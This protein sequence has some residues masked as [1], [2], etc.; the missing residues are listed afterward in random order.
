M[1]PVLD[2]IL[3][4]QSN[5]A[6]GAVDAMYTAL[7]IVAIPVFFLVLMWA[8]VAVYRIWAP[9]MP[10]PISDEALM[11]RYRAAS[12]VEAQ[13]A[14]LPVGV[15]SENMRKAYRARSVRYEYEAGR[16]GGIPVRWIEDLWGRRN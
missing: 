14:A 4:K 5:R 16:S 13:S 2:Q 7:M 6:G 10:E 11:M 1:I 12:S 9:D 3:K 8:V 15:R